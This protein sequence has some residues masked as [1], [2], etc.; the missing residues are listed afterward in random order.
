MNRRCPKK[1]EQKSTGRP[2]KQRLVLY[3]TQE[4]NSQDKSGSRK[5]T[6][7]RMDASKLGAVIIDAIIR[8]EGDGEPAERGRDKE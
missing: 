3:L 8:D 4:S 7:K 6:R 5:S 1:R 2:K